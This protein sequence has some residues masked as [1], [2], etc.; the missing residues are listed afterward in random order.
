LVSF[1][2]SLNL[3]YRNKGYNKFISKDLWM[4]NLLYRGRLRKAIT[5]TIEK[6]IQINALDRNMVYARTLWRNL[7][8]VA[9]P[10]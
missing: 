6:D 8:H 7:I 9:D 2:P 5:E 10:I 4:K 1:L 3:L